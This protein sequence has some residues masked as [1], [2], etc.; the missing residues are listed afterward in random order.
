[1]KMIRRVLAA[2]RATVA[3][4]SRVH[5]WILAE[6]C[7]FCPYCAQ[8]FKPGDPTFMDKNGAYWHGECAAEQLSAHSE[9]MALAC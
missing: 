1:M 4:W 3:I 9:P 8:P 5:R 2:C 7:G 6:Q